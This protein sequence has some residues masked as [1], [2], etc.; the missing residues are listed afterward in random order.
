MIYHRV[1]GLQFKVKYLARFNS[2]GFMEFQIP[3][4]KTLFPE[5]RS[6][7]QKLGLYWMPGQRLI[8]P[9]EKVNKSIYP[10]VTQTNKPK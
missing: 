9:S 8:E 1:N 10:T 7:E 4:Y 6:Y 3:T 5:Q 2:S